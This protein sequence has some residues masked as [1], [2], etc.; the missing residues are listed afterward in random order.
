MTLQATRVQ[1]LLRVMARGVTLKGKV[2]G[3]YFEGGGLSVNLDEMR[4][5]ERIGYVRYV[6]SGRDG[7][8]EITKVGLTALSNE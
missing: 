8:Y 3:R 2:N 1:Q 6:E 7:L 5:L 4:E